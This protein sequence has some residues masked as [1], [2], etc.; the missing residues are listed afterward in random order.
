LGEIF[1]E[2]RGHPPPS[3]IPIR[4]DGHARRFLVDIQPEELND[5]AH[6][7]PFLFAV[8]TGNPGPGQTGESLR[9]AHAPPPIHTG[10]KHPPLST[11]EP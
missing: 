4:D 11:A 8:A 2:T 1:S 10:I 6:G 3:Q 9:D 5:F 7:F